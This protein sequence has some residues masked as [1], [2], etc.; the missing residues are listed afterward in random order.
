MMMATWDSPSGTVPG[1]L[2]VLEEETMSSEEKG[3]KQF[4]RRE[5]MVVRRK[6]WR[7]AGRLLIPILLRW[8]TKRR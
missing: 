3:L 4:E 8:G 2:V 5:T 6:G 1:K 7:L